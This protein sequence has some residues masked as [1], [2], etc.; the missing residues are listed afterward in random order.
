MNFAGELLLDLL[1]STAQSP[2]TVDERRVDH[3]ERILFRI[4]PLRPPSLDRLSRFVSV[5]SPSNSSIGVVVGVLGAVG[6][7]ADVF[8]TVG[9]GAKETIERR[10]FVEE[11]VDL[12]VGD[13]LIIVGRFGEYGDQ[14]VCVL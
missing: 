1:G 8:E 4:V 3:A 7:S 6:D 2:S 12:F 13:F 10:F 11:G 9:E 5:S 14:K